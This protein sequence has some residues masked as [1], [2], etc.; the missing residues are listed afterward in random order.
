M[1]WIKKNSIWYVFLV[2][3]MA[4]CAFHAIKAFSGD[5]SNVQNMIGWLVAVVFG[6]ISH[7]WRSAYEYQTEQKDEAWKIIQE[8]YIEAGKITDESK[9]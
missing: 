6:Y 2:G 9:S 4:M 8:L 5:L 3:S 7:G 1:N